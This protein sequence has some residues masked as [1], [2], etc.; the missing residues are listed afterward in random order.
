MAN[1]DQYFAKNIFSS[2]KFDFF[3]CFWPK[4]WKGCFHCIET[5]HKEKSGV[6]EQK[7]KQQNFMVAALHAQIWF[8]EIQPIIEQHSGS[9]NQLQ[10]GSQIFLI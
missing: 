3:W 4:N 1:N 7:S 2:E 5:F 8:C 9:A 6:L 10:P